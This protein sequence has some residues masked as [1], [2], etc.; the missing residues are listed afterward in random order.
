MNTY[1]FGNDPTKIERYKSFWERTNDDRPLIGFT[2]VSWFPVQYFTV[3]SSWEVDSYVTHDMINPEEWLD[4]T[5]KLLIEGETI[6]DDILRGACPG[7]LAFPAFLPASLGS[8]IKVLPNT[9]LPEAVHL[10]WEKALASKFDPENPWIKT[11]FA[12]ADALVKQSQGRYP[13][14]HN[15]ELGPTDLHAILRGHNE[16]LIDLMDYPEQTRELLF[17]LGTLFVDA[18][19]G[20]WERLPLFHDGYFDA[21]YQLWAP[22]PIVRM[23]E[24][25]TAS[26]SP[27]LYRKLVQPVDRMIAE[28][29][30]NAFIHLHSTSMYIL[31]AFLEVEKIRCFEINVEPF[32]IPLKDMLPYFKMVQDA[33]RCLLI[34]G[35]FTPDELK[36]VRD[37]LDPRGLYVHIIVGDNKEIETLSPVAGL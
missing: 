17:T 27:D 29:F 15:G 24:D 21:Q 6:Q 12:F 19:K 18:T 20:V 33:D 5:E 4:D 9:V 11:Y 28:Q 3:S 8:E 30:P 2:Q 25:A 36:M 35:S 32:N 22:G 13:V 7:Q 16:A 37:N 14:S 1:P 10:P 31:D 34:R 23:Q 26:F